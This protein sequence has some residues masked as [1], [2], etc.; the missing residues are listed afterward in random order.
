MINYSSPIKEQRLFWDLSKM[1]KIAGKKFKAELIDFLI[2]LTKHSTE[3]WLG[4]VW[5]M[6]DAAT[7]QVFCGHARV[8]LVDPEINANNA[9]DEYIFRYSIYLVKP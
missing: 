3:D 9:T 8:I 4:T 5:S 1:F 6:F 2:L 7:F